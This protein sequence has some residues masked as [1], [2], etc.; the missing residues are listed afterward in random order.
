[1]AAGPNLS[2]LSHAQKDALIASLT[3]QVAALTA[4]LAELEAKLGLP[5]KKPDNSSVPPSKGQKKRSLRR[6]RPRPTPTPGRIVRSI[7]TR[8]PSGSCRRLS[9]KAAASTFR[10]PRKVLARP[11]TG[12]KSPKS[13]PTGDVPVSVENGE[14]GVAHLE[15]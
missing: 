14:V 7:P 4:R 6:P 10:A 8:P 12:S 3:A 11:T 2:N 9:A 15:P 5:P 1:M 13:S